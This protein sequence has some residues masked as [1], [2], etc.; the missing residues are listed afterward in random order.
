MRRRTGCSVFFLELVNPYR[1]LEIRGCTE[2]DSDDD[3]AFADKVG[4]T[5]GGVNRN[6]PP[7][8]TSPHSYAAALRDSEHDPVWAWRSAVTEDQELAN[9][10]T[11]MLVAPCRFHRGG[12]VDPSHTNRTLCRTNRAITQCRGDRA[13][14][15]M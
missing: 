8:P 15:W 11:N 9:G 14:C 5:Y 6:P 3:Y 12:S 10:C 7:S 13:G 2:I 4:R 1:T